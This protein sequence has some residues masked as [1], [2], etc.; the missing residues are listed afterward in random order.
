[1]ASNRGTLMELG[2][3][4]IV[5]SSM[6]MQVGI[7]KRSGL[8]HILSTCKHQ[9]ILLRCLKIWACVKTKLT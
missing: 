6:I 8:M 3:S 4:P 9:V 2:I 7:D 5:T 1:M